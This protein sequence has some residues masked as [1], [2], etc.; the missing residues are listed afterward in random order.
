MDTATVT[1]VSESRGTAGAPGAPRGTARRDFT[2]QVQDALAH[3]YDPAYLRTH[4]LARSLVPQEKAGGPAAAGEHAGQALRRRL[5]AAIAAL[6]SGPAASHPERARGTRLLRLRYVEALEAETVQRELGISRA[7]FYRDRARALDALVSLLAPEWP[8]KARAPAAGLPDV[9]GRTDSPGLGLLPA[10]LLISVAW[11]VAWFVVWPF[12]QTSTWPVAWAIGGAVSGL[13][14]GVIL[15][16]V[17]PTF[18][19]KQVQ[20]V[21]LGW[22]GAWLCAW[23]LGWSLARFIERTVRLELLDGTDPNSPAFAIARAGGG[24]VVGVMLREAGPARSAGSWSTVAAVALAWAVAGGV[25]H[26]LFWAL[27]PSHYAPG[28]RF[29]FSGAVEGAIGGGVTLWQLTHVRRTV[30]PP[31]HFPAGTPADA[32]G[33]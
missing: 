8:P 21:T 16:L 13:S 25:G 2:R 32:P 27:N 4:P 10:F 24:L 29:A 17:T 20:I 26:A 15:R 5:E 14:T 23:F 31:H 12:A 1:T 22:I 3:L 18:G 33:I 19:S 28:I 9:P 30:S 7:Q 11:G 6:E